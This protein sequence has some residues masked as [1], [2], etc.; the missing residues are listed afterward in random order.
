MNKLKFLLFTV[1]LMFCSGC[2]K[3]LNLQPI[4]SPTEGNYFVDEAGL[5]GAMSSCY[6]AFQSDNLYGIGFLVLAE[7]RGDNIS[8]NNAGSGGGI[9][10]QIDAF[11]DLANN[12]PVTN[13]WLQLFVTV[14][15]CNLVLEKA[16][17]INL[18]GS[19]R[20][21]IIGQALFLRALAYFHL[22]RLWGKVPLI[23]KNQLPDEARNNKRSEVSDIYVQ[24]SSDLNTAVGY[25]PDNWPAAERGRATSFAARALLA[26]IYLYQKKNNLVIST[27]TPLVNAIYS[28]SNGV[29]LVPQPNTFPDK[30]K[31]SADVLFAVQYLAGGVGEAVDQN[32]RY[33]YLG[34]SCNILLTQNMFED[35]DNRWPLV[36]QTTNRPQKFNSSAV[37]QNETSQDMPVL[38]CAEVL[39]L[40]AEALN[41]IKYPNA[42]AFKAVNAVRT[43]AGIAPFDGTKTPTQADLRTA[44]WKERRLELALECDRWFDIVRTGQF[45]VIFPLVPAYKVVYGIPQTEMNNIND[46][47]GWQND[48]Y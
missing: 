41:E 15:R 17:A 23:I 26:K 11:T 42:E 33:R 47:T 34:G 4:D 36:M 25:L 27:L 29:G 8:D 19:T 45:P 12:V 39:L 28:S 20:N 10:F 48:G 46:K 9:Y 13:A 37:V 1:V 24:I 43:N 16:P 14:Y 7:N 38:R 31:T 5:Q 30:I 3:F 40:Y 44:I 21:Q 18:T 2:Q 32:N 35:G 6:D 22:T